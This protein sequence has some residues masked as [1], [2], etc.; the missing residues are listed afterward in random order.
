MKG[1]AGWIGILV[2]LAILF[3]V[4]YASNQGLVSIPGQQPPG[5]QPG[6]PQAPSCLS[7][8]SP[9]VTVKTPDVYGG[10]A[11]T[12]QN[13]YRKCGESSWTDVAGAGTFNAD[14]GDKY[15]IVFGIDSDDDTAEP[16]GP[17][18]TCDDPYIVPC[19][20]TPTVERAVVDDSLATDLTAVAFDPDDGNQITTSDPI[21]IDA[22]D[23]K[24]I[25]F[26]WQGAF[27]EDFGNRFTGDD[28]NVLVVRYNT[29]QF[30]KMYVTKDDGTKLAPA[31][32]PTL[33]TSSSGYT[34]RAFKFPVLK[35]NAEYWFTLV[36][37]ADDSVNPTGGDNTSEPTNFDV[38][39]ITLYLYDSNW[40]FDNDVTP[41]QVKYGVEDEDFAETGATAA[42][43]L[44]IYVTVD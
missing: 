22:G 34:D 25:R 11:V 1:F 8:T 44:E 27:E 20:E 13:A 40:Y 30:D 23:I 41:A 37:D 29:T 6:T 33:L 9:T 19:Q 18:I 10:T 14:V 42:D 16:Y 7:T 31:N 2:V 35:S 24:N 15:E 32:V 21:D 43:T 39:N 3:G 26:K 38:S 36:A 5:Q 4:I 12:T 28:T 17:H